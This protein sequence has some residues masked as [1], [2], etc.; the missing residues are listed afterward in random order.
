MLLQAKCRPVIS[1]ATSLPEMHTKLQNH[2]PGLDQQQQ[3][4]NRW[5]AHPG[6][7]AIVEF[8]IRTLST[9]FSSNEDRVRM[10]FAK[11]LFQH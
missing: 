3:L 8:L 7:R 11:S 2:V 6:H 5:F 9:H 4:I 10:L 1:N